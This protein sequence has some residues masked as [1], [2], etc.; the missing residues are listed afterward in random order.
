MPTRAQC[1][2][3][4]ADVSAPCGTMTPMPETPPSPFPT[5]WS[6]PAAAAQ[7]PAPTSD[8]AQAKERARHPLETVAQAV[9]KTYDRH[10]RSSL[11]TRYGQM[12]AA[13]MAAARLALL[14]EILAPRRQPTPEQTLSTEQWANLHLRV[15]MALAGRQ[16]ADA[17]ITRSF[18]SAVAENREPVTRDQVTAWGDVHVPDTNVRTSNRPG[19]GFRAWAPFP[20]TDDQVQYARDRF[21]DALSATRDAYAQFLHSESLDLRWR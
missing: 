1:T 6:N 5:E 8:Q 21:V 19:V 13:G 17:A 12:L 20:G 7:I 2:S 18:L 4:R 14:R 11:F 3:R 16:T 15:E 9:D 10:S